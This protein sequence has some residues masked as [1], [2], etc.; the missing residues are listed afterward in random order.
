MKFSNSMHLSGGCWGEGSISERG[1]PRT[2]PC[3]VWA[4]GQGWRRKQISQ[5]RPTSAT[6]YT[7]S[8]GLHP[9]E[10]KGKASPPPSVLAGY[11]CPRVPQSRSLTLSDNVGLAEFPPLFIF[12]WPSG[13]YSG[14]VAALLLSIS[15]LLSL[16]T[17]SYLPLGLV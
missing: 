2:L 12:I 3:Q 17:F 1:A 8:A 11:P 15:Y 5:S 7:Q 4:Q 10:G 14:G 16:F 13:A 6:T 9:V